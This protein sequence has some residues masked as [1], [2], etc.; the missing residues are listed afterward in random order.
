MGPFI[1]VHEYELRTYHGMSPEPGARDTMSEHTM[2]VFPEGRGP[3]DITLRVNLVRSVH[4]RLGKACW[5]R[6]CFS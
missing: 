2:K 5:R 1:H 6:R 4:S 3:V